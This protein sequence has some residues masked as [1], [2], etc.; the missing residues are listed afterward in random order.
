MAVSSEAKVK[1]KRSCRGAFFGIVNG[2]KAKSGT[3]KRAGMKVGLSPAGL[4][5]LVIE[6]SCLLL[7][8]GRFPQ[9]NFTA[10]L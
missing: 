10:L 1:H 3:G 6:F 4:L 7:F 9:S 2:N 8:S 5:G